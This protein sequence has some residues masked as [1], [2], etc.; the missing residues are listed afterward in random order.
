M[1]GLPPLSVP[2]FPP[3]FSSSVFLTETRQPSPEF[4]SLFPLS[5]YFSIFPPHPLFSFTPNSIW[6]GPPPHFFSPHS[7][8]LPTRR[9]PLFSLVPPF[10]PHSSWLPTRPTPNFFFF[11][12]PF[13]LLPIFFFRTLPYTSHFSFILFIFLFHF[14]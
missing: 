1:V 6:A 7:P 10:S 11:P 2:I 12:S 4:F 14:P 9:P 8:G 5:L 13:L 3:F